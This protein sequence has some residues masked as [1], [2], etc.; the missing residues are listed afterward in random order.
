MLL[1]VWVQSTFNG[2]AYKKIFDSWDINEYIFYKLWN[3][4]T[5]EEYEADGYSKSALHKACSIISRNIWECYLEQL[6]IQK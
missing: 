4:K 2:G 6:S 5:K 1:L 3:V